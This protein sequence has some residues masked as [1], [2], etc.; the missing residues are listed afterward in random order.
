MSPLRDQILHLMA[1]EKGLYHRNNDL[2]QALEIQQESSGSFGTCASGTESSAGRRALA[3]FGGF[4]MDSHFLAV[5]DVHRGLTSETQ[6]IQI[7]NRASFMLPPLLL[8]T[9]LVSRALKCPW[10]PAASS[11]FSYLQAGERAEQTPQN[12]TNLR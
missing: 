12:N 11:D 6:G 4:A 5:V 7:L 9:F 10:W 2:Q 8:N 1:A 3:T